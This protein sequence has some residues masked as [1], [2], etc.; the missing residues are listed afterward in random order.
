MTIQ[1]EIIEDILNNLDGVY[2]VIDPEW[3]ISYI[4]SSSK[5]ILGF[6]AKELIDTDIRETLPDVISMFYKTLSNAFRHQESYIVTAHY[7]PTKKDIELSVQPTKNGLLAIFKDISVK[8]DYIKT[9]ESSGIQH[10]A[11]LD[12]ITDALIGIDSKGIITSF[13]NDAVKL[14]GY[15]CTEIIGENVSLL[16]PESERRSHEEYTAYSDLNEGKVIGKERDLIAIRKDG[17]TF[18]IDLKVSPMNIEGDYGY[19]GIIRDITERKTAENKILEE[20][21]IAEKANKAKSE[22]LSSMSHELRTPMNAVLGFS[23]LLLIKTTD[24]DDKKSINEILTAGNHLLALINQVLNLSKIESGTLP[25]SFE[26]YRLT[27]LMNDCLITIMPIANQQEIEINNKI[28]PLTSIMV[29]V[30]KT[31]F[32]QIILNLLSNAIKYNKKNGKVSVDCLQMSDNLLRITISDTGKG[33]NSKQQT[34]IFKPFERAGAENSHIPGTGL[35]L[36]ICKDLIEKMNGSIGFESEEGKGSR[37][38]IQ[39]PI[40]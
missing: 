16:L 12:I 29:K 5:N 19:L 2:M 25:L 28:D 33:L 32:R 21:Y 1:Y 24:D 31:H 37:F 6:S 22:F 3:N 23:Q 39:V 18:P 20:K 40:S 4:N 10:K 35:G 34:L 36:V 13:N 14:F 17:S 7:G 15:K 8:N 38:W 9:I 27:D 30:D 26:K 11:I